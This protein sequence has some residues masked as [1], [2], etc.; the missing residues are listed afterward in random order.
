MVSRPNNPTVKVREL[1]RR[2]YTAA[3]CNA[4]RGFHALYRIWR[5][6]VLLEAWQRYDIREARMPRE[7]TIGK[8]DAG[9]SHVRFEWGPQETE[10]SRHRA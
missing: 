3:K 6:D 1:Q 5:S 7:K 2:L 4:E 9:N 8:P 10:P